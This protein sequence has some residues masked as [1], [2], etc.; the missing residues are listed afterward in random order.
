MRHARAVAYVPERRADWE[1]SRR[2]ATLPQEGTA[3]HAAAIVWFRRDLRLADN[4][5]LL[6]AVARAG[7]IAPV[8][9]SAEGR[10]AHAPGAA[11]L[12]RE[13]RSLQSLA[14]SLAQKGC[15]LTLL[16]GRADQAIPRAASECGATLVT[17]SRD[18]T[19]AGLAE[20]RSVTAALSAIGVK[21]LVADGQLLAS[22]GSI[23]TEAGRPFQVFT[24]FYR[25]WTRSV[26]FTR[27]E[28]APAHMT[29]VA[30]PPDGLRL[31]ATAPAVLDGS[32]R[33]TGASA[34]ES[35][36]G[37]S[38]AHARLEEF[39]SG[40]LAD[41]ESAHDLP[42]TR[43]T[44]ELSAPLACGELSARQVG[45]AATQAAGEGVAAPF[46]RQLAWREFAYHVLD[47]HPQSLDEP[48][49]PRFAAMPW[50]DDPESLDAW[51][52]G[53][54]GWPLVDAGMRQL[55]HTGWMHNRV[56][57]VVASALTKDLL[58]PWQT[59][60]RA[61]ERMLGDYD[62]AANAFNWQWVS[63]SGADAAPYFRIFNPTLQGSRFD[64][65][66]EFVR[67]WVPELA[68][69][70]SRYVHRPWAAPEATLRAA[71]VRLGRDYPLQ[72]IDHAEGRQRALAAFAA[73]RQN[74]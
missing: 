18:W 37:E 13:R 3:V 41:Y 17:C 33:T 19:P 46:L 28:S 67:R 14:A 57:M 31:G 71:G 20:E 8:F 49:R 7:S 9:V 27:P 24:P 47:A 63:G 25:E 61:F 15:S 53:R 72:L 26:L 58:I 45:W 64:P 54:T 60:A 4:P 55:A 42:A 5:A 34:G 21:V 44:S 62:P 36:A 38:A 68:Q 52:E 30:R 59:G 39:A 23:L 66:G 32:G 48:L 50:R 56:R 22:P 35:A 43:G 69:M 65:A 1:Q 6:D 2:D 40:A 12:A 73:I 51:T 11:Y 16:E 29:S 10:D 74:S 70:P